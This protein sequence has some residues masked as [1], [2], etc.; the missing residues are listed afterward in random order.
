MRRRNE[1]AVWDAKMFYILIS[2]TWWGNI[3]VITH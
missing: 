1:G 2:L 3:S